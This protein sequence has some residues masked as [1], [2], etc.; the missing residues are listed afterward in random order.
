MS[1]TTPTQTPRPLVDGDFTLQ[2]DTGGPFSTGISAL[3]AALG[4]GIPPGAGVVIR[5]PAASPA[6][7]IA[8]SI[9]TEASHPTLYAA[10]TH[11]TALL[12]GNLEWEQ[13]HVSEPAQGS[14]FTTAPLLS[15]Q[16]GTRY[17]PLLESPADCLPH[18]SEASVIVDS[19][20]EYPTPTDE[21]RGALT[22]FLA[23]TRKTSSIGCLLVHKTNEPDRQRRGRITADTVD[24]VIEFDRAGTKKGTDALRIPK[25]R[26]PLNGANPLPITIELDVE[27]TV[28]GTAGDTF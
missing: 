8:Y 27:Q 19:I 11:D 4:G 1:D 28:G 7:R 12:E 24:I 25:L 2:T 13:H 22:S 14:A 3:D 6:E 16:D 5:Y 10:T 20:T 18:F 17:T 26:T 9:A 15:A 23:F 21:L